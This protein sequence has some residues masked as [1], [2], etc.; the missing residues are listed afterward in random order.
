M[1]ERYKTKR[2][3]EITGVDR[4]GEAI[5][6]AEPTKCAKRQG[7]REI[8]LELLC[9]SGPSRWAADPKRGAYGTE[10]ISLVLFPYK[11]PL[12]DILPKEDA[13]RF[14]E[15]MD[16]FYKAFFCCL[17]NVGMRVW[18]EAAR[19]TRKQ[20]DFTTR[21]D[22]KGNV[23]SWGDIRIQGKGGRERTVPMIRM[24]HKLLQERCQGI[25]ENDL[26]FPSPKTGRPLT[27]VR[28]AIAR[29]KEKADID[30]RIT[31]HL[32]RHAFATY[33]YEKTG[34]LQ[35][36]QMLLGHR[37]ISTTQIYTHVVSGHLRDV[38]SRGLEE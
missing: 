27:D 35:A 20:I 29:A 11:R 15:A 37:E 30:R 36:V 24:V 9:L 1:F 22:E 10:P 13:T 33:I 23:I 3:E 16:P 26:V 38:M 31:P 5:P 34:D 19:L 18:I 21:R 14:I 7:R 4:N 6:L 12:P 32:L 8:N 17:V 28:K 25:K 2:V